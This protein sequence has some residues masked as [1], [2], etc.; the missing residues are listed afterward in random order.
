[1]AK[2]RAQGVFFWCCAAAVLA[3]VATPFAFP[4]RTLTQY[5]GTFLIV[6]AV[7]ATLCLLIGPLIYG[8][9][10]RRQVR[11]GHDPQHPGTE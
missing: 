11:S 6:D 8:L 10:V 9:V 3:V 2:S 5:L 1:V 7:A 4:H